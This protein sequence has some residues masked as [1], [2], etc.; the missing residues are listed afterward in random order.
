MTLLK[1]FN[2]Y[3]VL[4]TPININIIPDIIDQI[5]SGKLLDLYNFLPKIFPKIRKES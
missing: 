1:V 3:S 5:L 2:I 4:T